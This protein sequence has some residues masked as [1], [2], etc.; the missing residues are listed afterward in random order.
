MNQFKNNHLSLMLPPQIVFKTTFT[1]PSVKHF[2]KE[3]S[4]RREGWPLTSPSGR[5]W[6]FWSLFKTPG[7]LPNVWALLK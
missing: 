3:P 5:L 1:S 7:N 4:W 2:L 6:G